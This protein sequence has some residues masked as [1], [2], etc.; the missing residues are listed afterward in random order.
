M[1]KEKLKNL[2][3][4][5]KEIRCKEDQ[6][7]ELS[8][9][10]QRV[11]YVPAAEGG[12]KGNRAADKVGDAVVRIADLKEQIERSYAELMTAKSEAMA[13]IEKLNDATLRLVLEKRYLLKR[14][15]LRI[16]FEMNYSV[17]HIYTLH[18][19]AVRALENI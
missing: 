5:E 17:D 13:A 11:T 16:A 2:F 8:S 12:G 4:L 18:R 19:K 3:Y 10:A 1:T 14:P 9:L 7:E 6:L 15:W